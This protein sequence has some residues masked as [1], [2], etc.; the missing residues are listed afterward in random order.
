MTNKERYA[1][2]ADAIG[3]VPLTM[4]PWW[5]D[6]VC[7]GKEWDV[8]IAEDKEGKILGAMPYLL[9]KR[10]HQRYILMPQM[11]QTGGI[12]VDPSITDNHWEIS[13]V[14]KDL[15]EQL[16]ALKISYYYQQYPIG[17]V[18]AKAM[19]SLG[20]KLRER[21]TYR[22]D[23]LSDFEQVVASFHKNKKRQI[24]KAATL[25]ADQQ[26]GVEDFYRFHTHCMR[27]QRKQILYTR[28][29]LLVLQRKAARLG[30]CTI[31]SIRNMDGEVCAAAFL[32]WDKTTMYYL[33]PCYDPAYKDSGAGALLVL[34][35]LKIAR[36]KQLAFDFEG[37]MDAGTAKHYSQFG[38]TPTTY[39]SVE[40]F[41]NPLFRI[42]LWIQKLRGWRFR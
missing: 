42:A 27:A 24:Q 12:W 16:K 6:A 19:E 41:Y 8:L 11:T 36:Q 13:Q 20:F 7:A 4:Q 39:Y 5:M 31:L 3:N 25:T 10:H 26:L 14:C 35:A 22:I 17:S 21:K 38:S 33:I 40:K 32:V 15:Q 30:Q 2:W 9:R 23:F 34:E 1:A 37:S 29:F 28:E 18:A